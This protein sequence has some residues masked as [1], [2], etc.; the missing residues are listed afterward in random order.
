MVK[1]IIFSLN[2][3]YIKQKKLGLIWDKRFLLLYKA[4]L[5]VDLFTDFQ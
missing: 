4:L 2:R 1:I 3:R 5:I